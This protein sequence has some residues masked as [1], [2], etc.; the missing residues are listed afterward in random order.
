M[1]APLNEPALKRAQTAVITR[2]HTKKSGAQQASPARGSLSIAQALLYGS[3]AGFVATSVK[4]ICELIAPPRA[5]GVESP[6]ANLLNSASVAATGGPLTESAKTVAEPTVHFAFGIG[7]A[8]VYAVVSQKLPVLRAGRGALFG[9]L[10]WLGFHEIGLP[11]FG[12]SP[13][14][15]QMSLWEQGNELVTHIVY[16]MVVEQVLRTVARKLA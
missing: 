12:F 5:P 9:F 16:G 4:T 11:L 13:T 1:K 6:L 8:A 3:V 15:A 7:A 2:R 14:P 10:F